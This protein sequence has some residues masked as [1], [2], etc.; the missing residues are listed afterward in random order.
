[1]IEIQASCGIDLNGLAPADR[2]RIREIGFNAWVSEVEAREA[3]RASRPSPTTDAVNRYSLEYRQTAMR[4][5]HRA[6][7]LTGQ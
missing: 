1:M 5:R 4:R 3:K 2:K 6:N 7:G